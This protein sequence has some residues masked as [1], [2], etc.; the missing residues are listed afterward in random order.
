MSPG[1]ECVTTTGVE[2]A[3]TGKNEGLGGQQ[4]GWRAESPAW[5][6]GHKEGSLALSQSGT[7]AGQWR[8]VHWEKRRLRD[9]LDEAAI[10]LHLVT[11]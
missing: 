10:C 6:E 7:G 8:T 2:V 9:K 5:E 4:Q 1:C 11:E 3:S